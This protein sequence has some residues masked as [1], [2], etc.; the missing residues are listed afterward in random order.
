MTIEFEIEGLPKM[1]N[2]FSRQHWIHRHKEAKKW[3]A[4]VYEK[5][6]MA[7]WMPIAKPKLTLVRCSTREP[8][9]DGLVSSFKHII[10]GLKE[11]GVILDDKQSVIGQPTYRWE[12]ASPKKGKIIV[13][14]EVAA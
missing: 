4:L 10:D 2:G 3:K 1:T 12:Y 8:D 7:P 9:F 11:V 13:K 6:S 14:V 5:V